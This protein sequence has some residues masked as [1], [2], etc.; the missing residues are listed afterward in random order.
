M[1]KNILVIGAT[2]DV[3]QGIC[4]VL[5]GAGHR[6]LG[7]SRTLKNLEAARDR[8]AAHGKLECL[9]GSVATEAEARALCDQAR[10]RLG[11]LD[12]V[13]T[14]VNTKND[15]RPIRERTAED[16]IAHLQGNLIPHFVAAKVFI[17][18]IEA[19]GMYLSIGGGMAEV[20]IPGN[21]LATTAQGAQ[22]NMLRM[23]AREDRGGPVLIRELLLYSHITGESNRAG[24]DPAW[25]TDEE[26]G[27]HVLAVLSEPDKFP[28]T[29][30]ALKSREQV[31]LPEPGTL[32]G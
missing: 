29:V 25:F 32:K 6:V 19:G 21:G 8:L 9:A 18:A 26:C 5:M 28:A 3:G 7:V 23:F 14:T 27:R 1:G 22:R 20:I 15:K 31:G 17:P 10:A 12:A 13:V 30:L 16:I 11:R 4:Q 24:A 2:G